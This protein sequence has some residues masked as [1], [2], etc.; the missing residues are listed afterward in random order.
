MIQ[1]IFRSKTKVVEYIDSTNI[2]LAD[3]YYFLHYLYV[4]SKRCYYSG[5]SSQLYSTGNDNSRF[6]GDRINIVSASDCFRPFLLDTSMIICSISFPSSCVGTL[7][8]VMWTMVGAVTFLQY[9]LVKLTDD[10]SKSWQVCNLSSFTLFSSALLYFI[11]GLGYHIDISS[12]DGRA[13][14]SSLVS[15]FWRAEK[16]STKNRRKNYPILDYVF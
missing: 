2:V 14:G 10:V 4:H 9:A 1:A 11:L 5:F 16:T 15:I 3:K 6:S 8:G 7:S 12:A 13:F